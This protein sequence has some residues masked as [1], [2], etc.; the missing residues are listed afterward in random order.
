MEIVSEG[1]THRFAGVENVLVSV[2]WGTPDVAAL[3]ARLPWFERAYAEHRRFGLL[4]VVTDDAAGKLPDR[5]F[6]EESR[7]QA[8]RFGS[9]LAFSGSVIEG[10]SLAHTLLRTLLRGMRVAVGGD[11]EVE[12]FDAVQDGAAWVESIAEGPSQQSLLDAVQA[13]R[14]QR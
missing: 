1:P 6:R 2:Y 9:A 7:L 12:F 3:K 4:V 11:V 5:A 14:P 8:A 13:L 10:T